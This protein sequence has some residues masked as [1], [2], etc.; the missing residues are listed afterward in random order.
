M[1]DN[2]RWWKMKANLCVCST[3]RASEK[4]DGRELGSKKN[5]NQIWANLLH[6]FQHIS[7]LASV[8]HGQNLVYVKHDRNRKN[9]SNLHNYFHCPNGAT[10]SFLLATLFITLLSLVCCCHS[11]Q[12]R[13]LAP[14]L[15]KLYCAIINHRKSDMQDYTPVQSIRLLNTGM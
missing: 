1:K 14:I 9:H 4:C 6:I 15:C 13:V 2:E 10:F 5:W 3:G 11:S 7:L 8:K 12:P